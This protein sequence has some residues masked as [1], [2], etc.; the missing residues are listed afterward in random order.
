MSNPNNISYNKFYYSWNL[1]LL[2]SITD[3]TL[4]LIIHNMI[5][6]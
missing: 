3:T 1:F 2:A 6:Q 5:F 4:L